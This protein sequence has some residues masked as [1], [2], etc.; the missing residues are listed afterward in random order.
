VLGATPAWRATSAMVTT[1]PHYGNAADRDN[2]FT[3]DRRFSGR[4]EENS[5][6]FVE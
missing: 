5:T 1:G 3:I 6:I 4:I 2:R